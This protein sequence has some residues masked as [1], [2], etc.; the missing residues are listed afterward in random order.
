MH[1]ISSPFL[2]PKFC[3][4]HWL[5]S[6]WFLALNFPLKL[7]TPWFPFLL[8]VEFWLFYLMIK[9]LSKTAVH[10]FLELLCSHCSTSSLGIDSLLLLPSCTI[11]PDSYWHLDSFHLTESTSLI[12]MF[13]FTLLAKFFNSKHSTGALF[14]FSVFL[15]GFKL[16]LYFLKNTLFS[17][18][19]S[20]QNMHLYSVY[21]TE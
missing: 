18:V 13:L 14:L 19:L 5:P 10:G 12:L 4:V 6:P 17:R 20:V 3:C 9:G 11:S 1:V 2:L 21:D 15:F 16:Q 8:L 7:I